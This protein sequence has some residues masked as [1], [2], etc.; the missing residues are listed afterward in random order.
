MLKRE[1]LDLIMKMVTEQN[2]I[3]VSDLAKTMNVSEMTIRR[4]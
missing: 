4:D 2:F 3:A 1:R